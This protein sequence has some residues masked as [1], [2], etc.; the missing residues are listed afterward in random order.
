LTVLFETVALLANGT[1]AG[2]AAY[3]TF[4]EHP[5]RL[6]CGTLMAATEF[7][8]SYRRAT[9]MQASLAVIGFVAS[10]FLWFQKR[11]PVVLVA[12]ILLVLVVP[13]TLLIIFPT[14]KRLLDPALD[15]S[16]VEASTLLARWGRLHA[17]RTFLSSL[18][19]LLLAWTASTH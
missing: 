11:D 16:S 8:P 2:A 17:V 7:G 12:A 9:V 1:F 14:N 10:A 5:A 4:V 19:F 6:E 3:I 18:S 13:F 15:R